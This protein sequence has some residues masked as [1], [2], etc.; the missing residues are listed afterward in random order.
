MSNRDDRARRKLE[1]EQRRKEK[2][3][4]FAESFIEANISS[5]P[6]V[7]CLPDFEKKPSTDAQFGSLQVPKQPK[8]THDGSRFG[9]KMTWC[10]RVADLN[11]QWSWR[12]S[13]EWTSDE[14]STDISNGLNNLENLDWSEIQKM[15]SDTGHL[16]HH[17]QEVTTLCDE[18]VERWIE[19]EYDQFD[20][21]FR[22]RLGNR[23]RAWGIENQGHFYLIWYER[24][25]Q[26]YPTS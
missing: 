21:V 7:Q 19:L 18:A 6:K 9:Y 17:D 1:R 15:N 8:T 11:G 4:K 13:R 20:T 22:F 25:H 26:I 3:V 5:T 2:S 10:A 16:M 24:N 23:K 14:W 12:E